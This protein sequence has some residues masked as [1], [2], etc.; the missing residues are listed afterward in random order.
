MEAEKADDPIAL[1][2]RVLGVTRAGFYAWRARGARRR[3]RAAGR[4]EL[5]RLVAWE[6]A[7]SDQTYGAPRI[8]VA[9]RRSGAR[10][11]AW[12]VAASMRRQGLSAVST[13]Q[14]YRPEGAEREIDDHEDHC[15]RQW[16]TGEVDKVWVTD[17]TYLRCGQGWVYLCA[18]RDAHSRRVLGWAMSSR[19]DTGTLIEALEMARTRRGRVPGGLV[20][21]ADRGAQFTS[22]KLAAYMRAA[23][24][25][26]SMGRT[27]VCWDNAMA[28]SF[29]ATLKVE[30]FYRRSFATRSQVYQG[31][32]EW[33]ERFYN[34][35]RIHTALG[36]YSPVEYELKQQSTWAKAA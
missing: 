34:R 25:T 28:E 6:F 12:A 19:Q 9:L 16:D 36:G 21:H 22:R 7:R 3:A 5:D 35:Q 33:I 23:G 2:A 1:M 26:V 11:G 18:V 8:T 32:G 10:V 20:L 31:V 13:R 14:F 29:W 4:R 30:Y 15:Q 24:A 17:F 27:G